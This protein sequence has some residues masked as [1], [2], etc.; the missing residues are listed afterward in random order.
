MVEGEELDA[1]VYRLGGYF[2]ITKAAC[3]RDGIVSI[4]SFIKIYEKQR[5]TTYQE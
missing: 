3:D 4:G 1:R 2:G 5:Q